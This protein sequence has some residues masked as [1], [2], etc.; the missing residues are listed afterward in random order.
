MQYR[1]A[2]EAAPSAD[3]VRKAMFADAR[4]YLPDDIL[5]KVDRA[6]MSVGLEARVP[7]LDHR[8]VRFGFSLPGEITWHGG[9][10][11]APLRAIARRRVRS[12]LLD[13]PKHG[14]GIPIARLLADELARWAEKYLAPKRLSEEGNLDP[15]GV[16]RLL[17]HYRSEAPA[18]AA[19]LWSLLCFQ[20]W[21]A[22]N[23]RGEAGD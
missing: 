18:D 7:I 14:F 23:H 17:A 16:E 3:P 10:T 15:Q 1:A 5:T 6:S 12:E 2:F 21:F 4:V 20:R 13:R 11:K 19:P 22:R 8:V 9:E